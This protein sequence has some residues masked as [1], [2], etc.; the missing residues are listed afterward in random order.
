M[1]FRAPLSRPLMKS[2]IAWSPFSIFLAEKHEKHDTSIKWR[3]LLPLFWICHVRVW[4]R[5]VFVFACNN[6]TDNGNSWADIY[7]CPPVRS[8]PVSM[9]HS[10]P[11]RAFSKLCEGRRLFHFC[12]K[13]GDHISMHH[14]GY[15]GLALADKMSPFHQ[16]LGHT[17]LTAPK[18]HTS[19]GL[20][21]YI[22]CQNNNLSTQRL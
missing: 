17:N 12:K 14:S 16:L 21:N 19:E 1:D 7:L 22:Q 9:L 15:T 4:Q 20:S 18:R 2:M 13:K 11:L 10:P 5:L 3:A 8:W 6:K